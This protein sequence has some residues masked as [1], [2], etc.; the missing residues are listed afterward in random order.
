MHKTP[1]SP[2]HDLAANASAAPKPSTLAT[3][4]GHPGV[5]E[6]ADSDPNLPT[7]E[8]PVR[9][10]KAHEILQMDA[11]TEECRNMLEFVKLEEVAAS[12][13]LPEGLSDA[14]RNARLLRACQLYEALDPKSAEESMLAIQ[15]VNTH[16]TS[17]ECIRL[18]ASLNA[19]HEE[20][21]MHLGLGKDLMHL[22]FQQLSAFDRHRGKL[23]THVAVENVHVNAGGRAIV[24]HVDVSHGT[25]RRQDSHEEPYIDVSLNEDEDDTG[26]STD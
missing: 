19:T 6:Q 16:L 5:N 9:A 22:Y 17:V 24:G 7:S 13:Q 25:V 20:R 21:K 8:V 14:E 12:I 3:S 26:G 2:K 15:M 23:Q 11:N 10:L 1:H 4:N 18:A